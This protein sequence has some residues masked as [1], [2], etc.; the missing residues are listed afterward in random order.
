M[1]HDWV[2]LVST[3]LH[4]TVLDPTVLDWRA[5]G[6][7]V[8]ESPLECDSGGDRSASAPMDALHLGVLDVVTIHHGGFTSGGMNSSTDGSSSGDRD[9]LLS[10]SETGTDLP[11][12]L[13]CWRYEFLVSGAYLCSL[14]GRP[15]GV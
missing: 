15:H 14:K 2:V 1:V 9:R 12:A 8:T 7:G 10:V 11:T 13:S 6:F 5:Q 3:L 4:R